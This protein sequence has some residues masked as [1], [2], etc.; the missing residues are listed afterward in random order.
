L[1]CTSKQ[2]IVNRKNGKQNFNAISLSSLNSETKE[3]SLIGERTLGIDYG[4]KRVGIAISAGFAPRPIKIIQN[5]GN[6][7]AIIDEIVHIA[8]AEQVKSFVV[9]IP[10]TREGCETN[11]SLVNRNFSQ[12]LADRVS[13]KRRVYVW[14]EAYSSVAAEARLTHKSQAEIEACL[15][16]VAACVILEDYFEED[17]WGAEIVSPSYPLLGSSK[18][19]TEACSAPSIKELVDPFLESKMGDQAKSSK[20]EKPAKL[21]ASAQYEA[22]KAAAIKEVQ[23]ELSSKTCAANKKSKKKKKKRR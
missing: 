18:S 5:Q 22:W 15:D 3:N 2:L 7:S 21:S 11:Q 16:S 14:N 6:N 4:L 17:G 19:Q 13:P 8:N 20:E 23:E 1:R 9:G 10:L 12:S